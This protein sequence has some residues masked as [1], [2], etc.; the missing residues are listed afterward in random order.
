MSA[1]LGVFRGVPPRTSACVLLAQQ[2]N[3]QAPNCP[4]PLLVNLKGVLL[5]FYSLLVNLK[6]VA[7]IWSPFI[8]PSQS[9]FDHMWEAYYL[10]F[11]SITLI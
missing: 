11:S 10:I 9:T 4:G 1:R 2:P 8:L 3:W 6:G 5:V 7:F